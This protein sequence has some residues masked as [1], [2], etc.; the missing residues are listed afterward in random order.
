M[1][2]HSIVSSPANDA[3]VFADRLERARQS[4]RAQGVD[5]ALLSLGLDMPYLTGYNAMP[6]ERLTMLVLPAHGDATIVVP[7]LEAP[8]VTLMPGVFTLLPWSETE[9]PVAITARLVKESTPES[10]VIAVGDQMWARFLVDLMPML[11]STQ[12]RRSVDVIGSLRMRKDQAEID[13]LRAAGAAVD[14]IAGELHAG[15]IPLVGRTEAQVSA[16]LSARILA[17]GHDVVNFAIVAAGENAASPHHHPGSRVIQKNEIVLCDFGGTMNGYCSDI[18]RC[19]FTGDIASDVAEA[20]AVLFEA[21]AAAVKAAT[22]GTPCEEVDAVARRIITAAGFGDYF[23]H[24][25]GHGIGL[26]AHE[27]PYIVSGNSLPLEAGHAFSVE[28]GIY[29]PGKWGMRLEDIV[30]AT[31]D[32]PDSMNHADHNLIA[33]DA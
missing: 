3:W 4:M 30:V 17:E 11:S 13:A 25:T 8:R 18:T 16:D 10:R 27:D 5:L 23:I 15:R 12:Y 22:I 1:S 14:R 29:L 7:G 2:G 19:V 32:G 9:D 24:R 28:P 26:D 20:Y 21:E 33:V 6:L 31:T